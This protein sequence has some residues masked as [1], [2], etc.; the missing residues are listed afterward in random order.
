MAWAIKQR[1]GNGIAKSVLLHLADRINKDTGSC[2]PKVKTIAFDAEVSED[3]VIK[4]IKVL[5]EKGLVE[6][7]PRFSDGVQ[8][9]NAYRLCV[10]GGG[11]T[12]PPG[13]CGLPGWSPIATPVVADSDP[14]P[15][16][17]PGREPSLKEEKE[18]AQPIELPED[19]KPSSKQ[20]EF[21]KKENL[22]IDACLTSMKRWAI[23][24]R[25]A[26]WTSVF[27]KFLEPGRFNQNVL[28][29]AKPSFTP[30]VPVSNDP[31]VFED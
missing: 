3:S 25:R 30:Y 16:R 27:N 24:K 5:K 20:V 28:T 4:S 21:A 23:G 31:I 10:E 18:K 29:T 9:S 17:E 2:I 22:N 7:I 1:V 15:V 8:I 14:E 19:F 12:D 13:R 26:N 11:T 6:V